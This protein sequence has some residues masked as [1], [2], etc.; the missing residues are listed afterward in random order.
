MEELL[1]VFPFTFFILPLIF[2]LHWWCISHF[3][4]AATKFCFLSLALGLCRP[5]SRWAS[6]AC[7]L[8]S[9]FLGL[10][11]ALYS[12]FEDMTINLYI[13]RKQRQFPLSVFVFI[14]SLVVS[15]SQDAGYLI[16]TRSLEIL[17]K[18]QI[19]EDQLILLHCFALLV[20][21][22]LNYGKQLKEFQA[23]EGVGE[24]LLDRCWNV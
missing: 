16:T 20:R 22:V 9:L 19:L 14:D 10:S 8:L 6:L 2:T 5:F 21:V 12:K 3:V 4:T 7:Q 13:T 1:Y 24:Y 17:K 15:A 18:F 23:M 11:L